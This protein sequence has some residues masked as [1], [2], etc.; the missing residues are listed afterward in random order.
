MTIIVAAGPSLQ[1]S[2]EWYTRLGGCFR[3]G[4]NTT[5]TQQK[6]DFSTLRN[7]TSLLA[8]WLS[9]SWDA[10]GRTI[11]PVVAPDDDEVGLAED[12]GVAVPPAWGPSSRGHGD[13]REVLLPSQVEQVELRGVW[14]PGEGPTSSE[15]SEPPPVAPPKTTTCIDSTQAAPCAARGEGVFSETSLV[16]TLLLRS[17]RKR[18][19]VMVYLPTSTARETARCATHLPPRRRREAPF[20][21]PR[22]SWCARIS[23]ETLSSAFRDVCL[24]ESALGGLYRNLCRRSWAVVVA[25]AAAGEPGVVFRLPKRLPFRLGRGSSFSCGGTQAAPKEVQCPSRLTVRVHKAALEG[26]ETSEGVTEAGRNGDCS[27]FLRSKCL[28]RESC[29]VSPAEC[30]SAARAVPEGVSRLVLQFSCEPAMS[31]GSMASSLRFRTPRSLFDGRAFSEGVLDRFLLITG[32][33]GEARAKAGS[34]A[35]QRSLERCLGSDSCK[36]VTCGDGAIHSGERLAGWPV[37]AAETQ[38][39]PPGGLRRLPQLHSSLRK[40]QVG[41]GLL[42]RDGVGHDGGRTHAALGV[43]GVHDLDLD[44]EHSLTELHGASGS[45]HEGLGGLTSGDDVAVLE[46]HALGTLRAQLPG[47]DDLATLGAGLHDVPQDA[48]GSA[49]HG[50]TLEELVPERFRL[51]HGA[52]TLV[53]DALSV[54]LDGVGRKPEALLDERGQLADA[55]GLLA[56]DLAGAGGADDD[57]R[58]DRRDAE[59]DA[60]EAILSKHAGEE[61]VE[62]GVEN[63]VVHEL[64]ALG[65]LKHCHTQR[66]RGLPLRSLAS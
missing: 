43:V 12:H 47:D 5:S 6:G 14:R 20:R 22:Q 50:Q 39:L 16:D 56:D 8:C 17:K 34:A 9:S 13:P 4:G 49:P 21:R 41:A 29:T 52:E 31:V 60:G 63:A 36:Y 54:E 27:E 58:A 65:F 26:G 40:L 46:L 11:L 55:A 44:A 24:A 19:A 64:S 38:R 10:R 1:R 61:L 53:L 33:G 45:A 32:D 28:D 15:E 23:P 2:A 18:S 37:R 35:L 3:V 48:V 66:L 59:L 30:K 42:D 25:A 51:S 7:H 62:L 57:L